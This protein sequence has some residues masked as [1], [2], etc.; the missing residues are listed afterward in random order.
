MYIY[1]LS[2][3]LRCKTRFVVVV[4][5]VCVSVDASVFNTVYCAFLILLLLLFCDCMLEFF[6][7][8]TLAFKVLRLHIN[9][10]YSP[11]AEGDRT[12]PMVKRREKKKETCFSLG[13]V[14]SLMDTVRSAGKLPNQGFV[15]SLTLSVCKRL[16]PKRFLT[17]R[18]AC[19][20]LK[21]FRVGKN[22]R[23]SV[24][25]TR[26]LVSSPGTLAICVR[27]S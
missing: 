11:F 24:G 3:H 12:S 15:P 26:H 19:A 1:Y 17:D 8:L 22:R 6:L 10:T 2:L 20:P 21:R 27:T 7:V 4:Y 13:N 16:T 5:N 23:N 18:D 9:I 14:C 25:R